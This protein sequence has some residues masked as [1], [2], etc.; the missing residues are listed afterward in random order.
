ML[1]PSAALPSSSPSPSPRLACRPRMSA[2]EAA[3]P[4]Q[5]LDALAAAGACL[6]DVRHST[7]EPAHT[8]VPTEQR[9]AVIGH[10]DS[11]RARDEPGACDALLS[12]CC[13]GYAVSAL[14]RLD[15]FAP[16]LP[17]SVHAAQCTPTRRAVNVSIL[18]IRASNRP[19]S[20]IGH[21]D[22]DPALVC[23]LRLASRP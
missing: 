21:S 1:P 9:V 10:P 23:P 6:S 20:N 8:P 16:S 5:C 12:A 2:P 7:S 22:V 18:A 19:P 11:C 4:A 15:A 17:R 14:S 13:V 3:V